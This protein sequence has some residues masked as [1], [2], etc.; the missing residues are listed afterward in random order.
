MFTICWCKKI[1]WCLRALHTHFSFSD[2][3]HLAVTWRS[4]E[5]CRV[6]LWH[7]HA[8]NQNYLAAYN[9]AANEHKW[10]C[11]QL[12]CVHAINRLRQPTPPGGAAEIRWRWRSSPSQT[13]SAQLS[14]ET[15]SSVLDEWRE[16]Q[17]AALLLCPLTSTLDWLFSLALC[18]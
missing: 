16:K 3:R 9:Y 1:T 5:H 11:K 6:T 7:W 13:C 10:L 17:L 4:Q 15:L 12:L 8:M 2:P 18:Q 14:A